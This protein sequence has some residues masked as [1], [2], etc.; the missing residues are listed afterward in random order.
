MVIVQYP[1]YLPPPSR[2]P[3]M[4]RREENKRRKHNYVPFAVTL[5]R[6]LA[7]KVCAAAAGRPHSFSISFPW[8]IFFF[9]LFSCRV[10]LSRVS[11]SPFS[12]RPF[13]PLPLVRH[14]CFRVASAVTGAMHHRACLL[15]DLAVCWV[16]PLPTQCGRRCT[17]L[18]P[19]ISLHF[20]IS[21]LPFLLH[22]PYQCRGM[23][24]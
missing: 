10:V 22:L 15:A 8:R 11:F 16:L 23:L 12:S 19:F 7:E 24:R 4:S 14:F 21:R 5:L 6:V 9:M 3:L 17:L 20:L 2:H 18:R 13:L 1:M